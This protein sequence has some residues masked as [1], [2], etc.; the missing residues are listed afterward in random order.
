MLN[1]KIIPY[2]MEKV[3]NC[4]YYSGDRLT[5][6]L[7]RIEK[8]ISAERFNGNINDE[9]LEELMFAGYFHSLDKSMEEFLDKYRIDKLREEQT[10]QDPSFSNNP[11]MRI[12]RGDSEL[13]KLTEKIS[14]SIKIMMGHKKGPII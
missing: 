2:L 6:R 8:I 9:Q 13:G 7:E 12:I 4:Q 5:T 14:D 1:E 10:F 11:N 3:R